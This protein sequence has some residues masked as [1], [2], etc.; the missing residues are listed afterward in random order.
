MKLGLLVGKEVKAGATLMSSNLSLVLLSKGLGCGPYQGK[1]LCPP[2]K[3]VPL[4]L[5]SWWPWLEK[6]TVEKQS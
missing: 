1:K 2:P 6:S 5:R 3:T 4:P